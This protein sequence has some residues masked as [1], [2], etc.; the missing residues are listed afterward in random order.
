MSQIAFFSE[1]SAVYFQG[2]F[3]AAAAVLAIVI[4]LILRSAQRSPAMPVVVTAAVSIPLCLLLSR[5]VHWYCCYEQY[6]SFWN[7]IT[8]IGYGGFSILGVLAGV[9]AAAVISCRIYRGESLTELLDCIAPAGAAAISVGRLAG[10]FTSSDRG[11]MIMETPFFQRLPF[12]VLSDTGAGGSEWSFATFIFESL[13]AAVIFGVT[14]KIFYSVYGDS[15]SGREKKGYTTINFVLIFFALQA[16]LESTRNDALFLR[17]NGFVSMM[18]IIGIIAIIAV[19]A[20]LSTKSIRRSGFSSRYPVLWLI[21]VALLGGAGGLEYLVQR[22][23]DMYVV[24]YAAM[25]MCMIGVIFTVRR[26]PVDGKQTLP[27]GK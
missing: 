21:T 8:D 11:K 4:S 26:I 14:L 13:A 22:Y 23:G 24:C 9:P 18:Q 27:S 17:S 7:A 15:P 16:V 10:L 2:I 12:A 5:A 25:L 20:V 6:Q 3:I 19:A 1:N